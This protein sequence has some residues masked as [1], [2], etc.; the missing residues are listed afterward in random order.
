MIK[1]NKAVATA[2]SNVPP[3]SIDFLASYVGHFIDHDSEKT[4]WSAGG[5]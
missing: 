4:E 3:T 2:S 5:Y 1:L